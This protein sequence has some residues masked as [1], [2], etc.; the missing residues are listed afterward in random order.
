MY[1]FL[2]LPG[3]FA[4]GPVF[5]GLLDSKVSFSAGAGNRAGDGSDFSY[6]I[7]EYANLR[8]QTKIRD[9]AAFYGSFNL[10]ALSGTFAKTADTLGLMNVIGENYAA[11]MELERLYFRLNGDRLDLDA[12]L[13]RLGFGYGQVF[14]PSDFLNPRNPLFPDAR[15]RGILGVN[16]SAYPV[17]TAKFTAFAVAGKDPLN[18]EGGGVLFGLSGENHWDRVS[19]QF[20]YSFE[21]PQTGPSYGIHRGGLSLK[22]DVEVGIVADMLYTINPEAAS[23]WDG[24]SVSAGFDYNFFKG[25]LY[26]LA[27]Y[28]YSGSTSSTAA[29]GNN[30]AGFA[31]RNYLYAMAR[32]NF[33]DYTNASLGCIMG[34]DDVSFAPILSIEHDLFQGMTLMMQC[35][36]PLDRDMFTNNGKQGEFGPI[37]S[38]SHFLTD[39]KV[40][41]RF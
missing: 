35:Q 40:R 12:G 20:L 22:A 38:G 37:R 11:V 4:E 17:D 10:L 39:V 24:V 32:Y 14:A 16:A 41:L 26:V 36:I 13:M 18:T 3:S 9:R 6:G 25:D 8:V 34:M 28:L 2:V 19:L 31:K 7:E 5:S 21:T 1:F 23:G 29:S 30:V 33:S 27:E 15:P